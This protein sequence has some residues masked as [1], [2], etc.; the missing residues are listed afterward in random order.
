[1]SNVYTGP[2]ISRRKASGA[3]LVPLLVL[4]LI[5]YN[6]VAFIV[7][8]GAGT[9]W[10]NPVVSIPMVSR[11]VWG[12]TAGD[13]LL[14]AGLVCLFF[15]ILKSTRTGSASIIEH[16]FSTAVFVVFLVEFLLVGAAATSTFF[17]LMVM[18]LIDVVAGFSV[19]I[20]SAE[21]DVSYN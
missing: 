5:I 11:A 20:T 16:I 17:I 7:F 4:P 8:G 18:S 13:L 9:G 1:M 3:F 6:I 14:L 2:R 15:E 19:S 21:R 12:L 10:A